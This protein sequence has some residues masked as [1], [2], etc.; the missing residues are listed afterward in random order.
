MSV[1]VSFY[2]QLKSWEFYTLFVEFDYVESQV[3]FD[4]P[5]KEHS[6]ISTS[7]LQQT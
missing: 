7:Q 6:F 4:K 2:L 3:Q 1:W 5:E